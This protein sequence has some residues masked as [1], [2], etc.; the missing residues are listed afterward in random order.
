MRGGEECWQRGGRKWQLRPLLHYSVCVCF[1]FPVLAV[2]ETHQTW[3]LNWSQR[4]ND[5]N[6]SS[7][8]S[9]IYI[10]IYIYICWTTPGTGK[11]AQVR[12]VLPRW[13]D[14]QRKAYS[15]CNDHLSNRY[16]VKWLQFGGNALSNLSRLFARSKAAPT[17]CC[18]AAAIPR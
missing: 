5:S 16:T 4:L 13:F 14:V 10:Y 9:L 11:L 12:H 15:S 18:W 6:D 17:T 3:V 2:W 7:L 8:N 1:L